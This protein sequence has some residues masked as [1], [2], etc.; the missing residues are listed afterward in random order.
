M[1]KLHKLDRAG[2]EE[3]VL[4]VTARM[5]EHLHFVLNRFLTVHDLI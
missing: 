1:T 4:M 2:M 3:L 5:N